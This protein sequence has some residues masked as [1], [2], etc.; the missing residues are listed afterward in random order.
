[1]D[2]LLI[3]TIILAFATVILALFTI[4]LWNETKKSRK[5]QEEL[6]SPELSVIIYPSERVIGDFFISIKNIG[7]S[8][9]YRLKLQNIKGDKINTI[10]NKKINELIFLKKINYIRPHQEIRGLI[11]NQIDEET[12]NSKFQLIF[13]Y[14]DK[15]GN[16]ITERFNYDFSEFND[17]LIVS[18]DIKTDLIKSLKKINESIN[19]IS[20][21]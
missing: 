6:N 15:N 12:L 13:N 8:P 5:F 4:L 19:K 9:I 11:I 3:S 16:K 17:L 21:K 18:D 10:L 7:K 20:K 2:A 14:R 1:M